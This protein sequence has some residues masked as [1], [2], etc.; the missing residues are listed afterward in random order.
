M[1]KLIKK[2][3]PAE[4]DKGIRLDKEIKTKTKTLKAMKGG[5]REYAEGNK[6]YALDGTTGV[7]K[8]SSVTKD[9]YC[10]PK[11]LLEVL[12]EMEMDYL[13]FD[14]ISVK[15]ADVRKALGEVHAEELISEVKDAWGRVT[16][17]SNK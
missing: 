3:V 4:V 2:D 6:L 5:L 9:Q 13:F 15:I 16:F 8:F 14:L 12:K 10:D 1:G 7:V 11:D 17:K